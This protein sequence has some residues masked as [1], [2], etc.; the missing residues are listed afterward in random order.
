MQCADDTDDDCH[1]SPTLL[2]FAF[3]SLSPQLTEQ[4]L[5]ERE[6][7]VPDAL[8]ERMDLLWRT[9]LELEGV[10]RLTCTIG[11]LLRLR[12]REPKRPDGDTVL[13]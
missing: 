7:V 11:L 2:M 9:V 10:F 13:I 8:A 5:L 1:A 3:L 4:P 12:G 6:C